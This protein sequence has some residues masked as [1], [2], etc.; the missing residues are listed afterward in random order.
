M[1][2][3]VRCVAEACCDP[4]A[5]RPTITYYPWLAHNRRERQRCPGRVLCLGCPEAWWC[6]LLGKVAISRRISPLLYYPRAM[7]NKLLVGLSAIV[8]QQAA[9]T[10]R[11]NEAINKILDYCATTP[12]IVFYIALAA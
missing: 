5:L 6:R 10:Q 1:A 7:D 3:F 8:S 12:K 4:M 11:T 9:A 2:S